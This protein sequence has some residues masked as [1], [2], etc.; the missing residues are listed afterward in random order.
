MHNCHI[1]LYISPA[2]VVSDVHELN[3]IKYTNETCKY[4]S[5]LFDF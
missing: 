5:A 1:S 2:R 4:M 3:R